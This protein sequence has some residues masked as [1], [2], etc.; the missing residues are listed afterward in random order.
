MV[1]DSNAVGG[2]SPVLIS[3]ER[4][5]QA[6]VYIYIKYLSV[7]FDSHQVE[8]VC[9]QISQRLHLSAMVQDLWSG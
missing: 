4:H 3:E 2:Y 5:E 8:Y 7:N 9:A 6:T 1:M